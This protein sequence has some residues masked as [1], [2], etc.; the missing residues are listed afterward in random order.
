[1]KLERF[2][3]ADVEILNFLDIINF[4][5]GNYLYYNYCLL[6]HGNYFFVLGLFIVSF[7]APRI[8]MAL[9]AVILVK[10]EQLFAR[11]NNG[12]A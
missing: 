2:A 12:F 11:T 4:L 9:Y 5:S 7:A 10:N 6:L 3:N 1:M 8:E